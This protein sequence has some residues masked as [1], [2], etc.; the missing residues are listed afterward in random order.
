[1]LQDC[2]I[3]LLKLHNEPWPVTDIWWMTSEDRNWGAIIDHSLEN[4][5]FLTFENIA[6]HYVNIS[7]MDSVHSW[8][9]EW[10]HKN[11]MAC[12][13]VLVLK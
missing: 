8:I 11:L 10:I 6:W 2:V 7:G 9:A 4:L 1:M 12:K 3:S 5:F 13:K